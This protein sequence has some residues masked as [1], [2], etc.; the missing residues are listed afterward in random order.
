MIT[1]RRKE[2]RLC[3]F[4]QRKVRYVVRYGK[5]VMTPYANAIPQK[6]IVFVD[7][8]P[9]ESLGSPVASTPTT[10]HW[11]QA[12]GETNEND[13]HDAVGPST[14]LGDEVRNFH[15]SLT[16]TCILIVHQPRSPTSP[17]TQNLA[18]FN[19]ASWDGA[20]SHEQ[21]WTRDGYDSD[22]LSNPFHP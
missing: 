17:L 11:Q 1:V 18:S 16:D 7:Y 12:I 3:A 5:E 6:G 20:S 9:T 13:V 14:R 4:K 21:V 2:F 10:A 19:L 22:I 8:H 15:P